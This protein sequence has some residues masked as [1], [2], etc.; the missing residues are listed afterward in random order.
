MRVDLGEVG[1]PV[2]VVP[3]GGPVLQ[4]YSLVLEAGSE[5]DR[6]RAKTV[7]VVDAVQHPLE[8]AALIKALVRWIKTVLEAIAGDTSSVV[9]GRAVLE[10]VG[11]HEVE[12][13]VGDR[14]SQ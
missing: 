10:S 13:L 3:R 12:V 8:V 9:G 4:L 7:D 5:P 2:S 6:G 14:G 1:D 11:H